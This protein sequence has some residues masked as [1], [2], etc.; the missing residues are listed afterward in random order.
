MFEQGGG[1]SRAH[2]SRAQETAP[3]FAEAHFWNRV[4]LCLR[5]FNSRFAC[6]NGT[7]CKDP[8]EPAPIGVSR[9]ARILKR[10]GGTVT[11]DHRFQLGHRVRILRG[12]GPPL[13]RLVEHELTLDDIVHTVARLL[14]LDTSGPVYHVAAPDGTLRL[15][16]ESQWSEVIGSYLVSRRCVMLTVCAKGRRGLGR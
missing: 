13:E 5:L 1:I 8:V 7:P 10:T 15:V 4:G 2:I 6:P 16:H 9:R 14:P 3:S 12:S 11:P